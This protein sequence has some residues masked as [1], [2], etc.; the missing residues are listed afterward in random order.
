MTFSVKPGVEITGLHLR[1]LDALPKIA[2]VFEAFGYDTTVTSGR[3]GEHMNGSLHYVGRALDFRTWADSQGTQLQ[4]SGKEKIC[5][6]I[7]REI[8]YDFD[9]IPERTHIHVELHV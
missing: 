4:A 8:G 2:R 9:V 1:M 5:D 6:E 7:L 3:D